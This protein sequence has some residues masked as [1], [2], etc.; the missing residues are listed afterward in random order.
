MQVHTKPREDRYYTQPLCVFLFID[1]ELNMVFAN[2]LFHMTI[3]WEG[4]LLTPLTAVKGVIFPAWS[5]WSV[6]F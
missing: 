3:G 2:I 4:L 1:F 5:T 6:A